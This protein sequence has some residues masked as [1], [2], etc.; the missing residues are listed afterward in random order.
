VG[1]STYYIYVLFVGSRKLKL[2]STTRVRLLHPSFKNEFE[3]FLIT[4]KKTKFR[5]KAELQRTQEKME[6]KILK[7]K[8]S[9][10]WMS[11]FCYLMTKTC[12]Y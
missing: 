9:R 10:S 11:P 7:L 8:K 3:K 1:S 6:R 5:T 4:I 12:K 2:V